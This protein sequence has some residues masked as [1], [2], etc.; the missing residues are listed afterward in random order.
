MNRSSDVV[1]VGAGAYGLSTAFWLRKLRPDLSV[2][3]LDRSDF[4][5]NETGRC[6]AGIRVQWGARGNI[7]LCLEAL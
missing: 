7:R 2:T 5:G 3:S 1:I 4:A 6:G